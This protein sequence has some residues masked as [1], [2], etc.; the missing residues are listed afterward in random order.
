MTHTFIFVDEAGDPGRP[1]TVDAQGKKIATGSSA[2]YII[3][4]LCLDEKKMFLIEHQM[5]EV[6]T[7]FGYKKEIKSNEISL[8]LYK[9]LL[10]I[11]DALDIQTYFRLVDKSMYRGTFQ[12]DGIPKLHN[13]FDEYNVARAVAFAIMECGFTDIDVVIDRTDRRMLD[14]KFD[15]FNDYL[16][17]K[18]KKYVGAEEASRIHHVTHVDSKYVNAMQMSDIIGGAIRDNFTK[19]NTD[20]LGFINP[21]NLI[22]VNNK[23]EKRSK[24]RS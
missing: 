24:R 13:V 18:V 11:L 23:H 12:V 1:F 2:F 5:T 19:K 4:A 16:I 14:G 8:G 15:A 20:L 22:E 9:E 17:G 7:K 10:E 6:K 21:K 3:S